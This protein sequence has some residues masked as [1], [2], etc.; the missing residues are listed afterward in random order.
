[1]IIMKKLINYYKQ[2]RTINGYEGGGD[3]NRVKQK[4]NIKRIFFVN[5]T[6]LHIQQKIFYRTHLHI[7]F[8]TRTKFLFIQ[9]I[10]AY[11][12]TLNHF[13]TYLHIL[14]LFFYFSICHFRDRTISLITASR[15]RDM[16]L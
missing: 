4:Q 7:Y 5:L 13:S 3:R 10:C 2:T 11:F 12:E 14:I 6:E 16:I 8:Q 9:Q 1:M 15:F